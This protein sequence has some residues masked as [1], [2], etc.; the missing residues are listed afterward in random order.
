MNKILYNLPSAMF[1]FLEA[2]AVFF[3]GIEI[4]IPV[5]VMIL[6]VLIFAIVRMCTKSAKHYKAWYKCMIWSTILMISLLIVTKVDLIIAIIMAV[7]AAIILSGKGDIKD[8][9]MWAN[10]ESKFSDID[11]Y[12][13]ENSEDNNR[14]LDYEDKL[15]SKDINAY[16]LYQ[17]RFKEKKTFTEMAILTN[18]DSRRITDK[19][20]EV[21]L[22]IRT[23]CDI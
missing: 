5:P 13:E 3:I 20:N 22:S 10:K 9:F 19:L 23:F 4:K 8:C 16:I 7:F 12:L 1:N 14:L 11:R 21:A 6:I 15:K 17:Y 2:A 18:M